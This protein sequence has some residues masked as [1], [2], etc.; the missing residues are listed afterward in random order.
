MTHQQHPSGAPSYFQPP[1]PA[2]K[3]VRV[4]T[5]IILAIN[6]LFVVWLVVGIA[7][8]SSGTCDGLTQQ[9]CDA[10]KAI[11]G[12][13]GA[14]LIIFLWVAADVILGIIWLVTRKK[15][16]TVVYVQQ[17]PPPAQT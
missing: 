13:I 2:K 12:G 17:P 4:F 7:G 8:V 14:L 10:A 5:W 6:L 1:P 16:P 15:E 9:N 3:K 11:G